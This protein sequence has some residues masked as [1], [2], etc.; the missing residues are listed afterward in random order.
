MRT[1]RGDRPGPVEAVATAEAPGRRGEPEG[2]YDLAIVGSGGGAMAAAI[3]ARDMGARVVMVERGTVG[4]TCVNIGCIP[5]KTLL[6][7][8]ELYH[9]AG[10]HP[11]AGL[12]T[13]AGAVDMGAFVGQK[14]ELVGRL[15][16]EKYLDLVENYG[17][18][19]VR[20]E[21]RFEDGRTLRVGQRTI[22]AAKVVLATGGRPA[23]PPIP[24]LADVDYL[25]STSALALTR[26]PEHLVVIGSGYVALELGSVFRRLGSRVTLLQ[27]SRRVLNEYDPE[28]ADAARAAFEEDGLA[29]LPGVQY[30]RVERTATGVAVRVTVDGQPRTVEGGALLV[31]AGR[32]PNTEAL[33]LDRAGIQLGE[34]GE[35]AIDQFGRTSNRDVYAAGDVTLGPQFVYVAAYEGALAADNALRGNGRRIDLRLVPGVTF[36]NPAIATVG[37]TEEQARA[38]G[39]E[40]KTAI[41]PAHAVPRALVNRDTRGVVKLVADATSDRLLG[42]HV[43]AENAGDVIYAAVLAL[44]FK[45]TVADLVDTFAPYLTMAEGLK[46]AAQAFGRDLAKLS[47]CAA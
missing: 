34:R 38:A 2:E 20:G 45:A 30:D 10:H 12:G 26:L 18:E 8:S 47:C 37:L 28:V 17:W 33:A 43:V 4:G 39:H 21:A 1:L 25:T 9:Q 41:L 19:L 42:A 16:Q 44:R 7:G 46:L 5:S 40:V 23:V 6:R 32:T 15:R 13:S 22:R 36:T 29:F 35:I 11:F 14:D 3:A 31:A 27:R 24:G